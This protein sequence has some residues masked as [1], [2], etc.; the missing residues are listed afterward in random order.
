M[1]IIRPL[2]TEKRMRKFRKLYKDLT[3]KALQESFKEQ[4]PLAVATIMTEQIEEQDT[5]TG[6]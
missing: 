6:M 4:D 5:E 1:D 3:D 2:F